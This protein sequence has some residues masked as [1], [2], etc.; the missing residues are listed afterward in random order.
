MVEEK[1]EG[2]GIHPP[3]PRYNRVKD[4]EKGKNP[5]FGRQKISLFVIKKIS[6][7]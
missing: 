1:H 3:P 6:L 7:H 4:A 2:G 5:K